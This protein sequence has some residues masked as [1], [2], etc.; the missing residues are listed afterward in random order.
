MAESEKGL[1]AKGLL[2]KEGM[3]GKGLRINLGKTKVMVRKVKSEPVEDSG[4]WPCGIC[5]TG[6]GSNS[7][8][9]GGCNKSIHRNC[10]GITGKLKEDDDY[11]CPK[12]VNSPKSGVPGPAEVK[13]G[14]RD[15]N[16][17]EC[18]NRFCY[19]GDMIGEGGGAEEASRTRVKCAWG[20]Y[21]ELSP[22][23]ALRGASLKLMGKIYKTCVQSVLIYGS[24]T[25]AMKDGQ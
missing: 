4:K 25:W 1:K 5:R 2:W 18:V 17:L 13:L 24:E 11:R 21:R 23:L 19:L 3:E 6:V 16:T 8:F 12:C 14:V 20:K 22:I 15:Q 9:C 7:I 10:S